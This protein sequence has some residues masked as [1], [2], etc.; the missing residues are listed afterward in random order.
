MELL[1]IHQD[2]L[3]APMLPLDGMDLFL[4]GL[5]LGMGVFLWDPK[6]AKLAGG[7][8][9]LGPFK[10]GVTGEEVKLRE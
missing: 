5:R 4:K 3:L 6:F 1:F 10:T 8:C 7:E 2:A 9:G